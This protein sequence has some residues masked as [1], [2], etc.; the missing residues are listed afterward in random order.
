M[1]R[2]PQELLDRI[3]G[4]LPDQRE[5]NR[6]RPALATLSRPWQYAIETFTFA[7][8]RITSNDLEEFKLV[9]TASTT[10]RRFLQ[11]FI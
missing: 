6:I 3:V 9:F 8:L 2:L 10:R 7:S 11:T 1:D 5:G 4:Y